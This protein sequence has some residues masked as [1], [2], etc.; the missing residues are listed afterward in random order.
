[1]NISV[2]V[3]GKSGGATWRTLDEFFAL[4]K[5][6]MVYAMT[7]CAAARVP[8]TAHAAMHRHGGVL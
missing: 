5:V 3:T 2:R 4:K 6:L 7:V 1:M 8:A